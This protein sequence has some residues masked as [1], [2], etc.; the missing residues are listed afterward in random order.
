MKPRLRVFYSAML[1]SFIPLLTRQTLQ[2]YYD[3]NFQLRYLSCTAAGGLNGLLLGL[4][5]LTFNNYPILMGSTAIGSA[6]GWLYCFLL[7][8]QITQHHLKVN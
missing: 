2:T 5:V 7:R 6:Y 4:G 1:C 3:H 8:Q